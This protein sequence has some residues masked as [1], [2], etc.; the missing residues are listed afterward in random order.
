MCALQQRNLR[1]SHVLKLLS[2]VGDLQLGHSLAL[3]Q[4]ILQSLI[5]SLQKNNLFLIVLF[6]L[7]VL[8]QNLLDLNTLHGNHVLKF[9]VLEL[10]LVSLVQ[11][12]LFEVLNFVVH[13]PLELSLQVGNVSSVFFL[14]DFDLLSQSIL[15]LL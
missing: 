3:N 9:R 12:H 8:A 2:Q 15:L 5:F 6:H 1:L 7:E 14:L 13:A 11:M 10:Q 4:L